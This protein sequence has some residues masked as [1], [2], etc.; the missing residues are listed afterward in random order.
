MYPP[1]RLGGFWSDKHPETFFLDVYYSGPGLVEAVKVSID[2]DIL[3][4]G[5]DGSV[6]Q[7]TKYERAENGRRYVVP[8]TL[9]ERLVS[10]TNAV[11]QASVGGEKTEGVFKGGATTARKGFA[12]AW[13]KIQAA[14]Q[15]HL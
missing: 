3:S 8:I 2:G 5:P 4:L 13:P 11:F 6:I 14:R 9:V 1:L 15:T 7:T 10:S 12:A